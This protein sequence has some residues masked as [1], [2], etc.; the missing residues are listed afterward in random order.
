MSGELF[1]INISNVYVNKPEYKT[2]TINRIKSPSYLYGDSVCF[3]SGDNILLPEDIDKQTVINLKHDTPGVAKIINSGYLARVFKYKSPDGN[4]YAIKKTWPEDKQKLPYI[5]PVKQLNDEIKAYKRLGDIKG[6]PKLC[7]Y[8]DEYNNDKN[9]NE[10]FLVLSWVEG[11][12]VSKDSTYYDFDLINKEK[13]SKIFNLLTE[14]DK[15]GVLHNDLWAANILFTDNDVN[16]VDFN[17][18]ELF[19]PHKEYTKSNLDAF[20]T[21]FLHRYLSDVNDRQGEDKFLE[22]YKDVLDLEIDQLKKRGTFELLDGNIKHAVKLVNKANHLNNLN[23]EDI[24]NKAL[25]EIFDSDFNCGKIYTKYFE[26]EENESIKSFLKALELKQKYPQLFS[27]DEKLISSNLEVISNINLGIEQAKDQDIDNCYETFKN[28]QFILKNQSIYDNKARQEDYYKKM[29]EFIRLNIDFIDILKNKSSD[30]ALKFIKDRD[31]FFTVNKKIGYYKEVLQSI[32]ANNN[33]TLDLLKNQIP[34]VEAF[35]NGQ[36][37][38]LNS[39]GQP[40][41]AQISQ[42]NPADA[43]QVD[44]WY[45]FNENGKPH[46]QDQKWHE[47]WLDKI[48]NGEPGNKIFKIEVDNEIQGI[49]MIRPSLNN[50]SD[51]RLITLVRGLR[52]APSCNRQFDKNPDYKGVGSALIAYAAVESLKE[53]NV[54]IGINSSKGAEGFYEKICGPSKEL[55][56]DGIRSFFSLTD[57]ARLEF[58]IKQFGKYQKFKDKIDS[59]S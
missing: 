23:D 56:Y 12:P 43:V 53:G 27:V 39:V 18:A 41:L 31:Q 58:L 16:I 28:A 33:F 45:K 15:K 38:L 21:R 19:D 30:D 32:A 44:E 25:K 1:L 48:S 55:A 29:S 57:N 50:Y 22:V 36:A 52:I 47:W 37:V 40:V 14:F 54:G 24:K 11:K 10:H 42:V 49:M 26:F 17:R 7:G 2:V 35:C 46:Y 3:R 51:K 8:S 5:N 4:I 34:D 13:L 59:E 9:L 20:K 6:V